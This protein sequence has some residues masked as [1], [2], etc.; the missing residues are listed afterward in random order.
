[1]RPTLN[2]RKKKYIHIHETPYNNTHYARHYTH[3]APQNPH[4]DATISQLTL[5][6]SPPRRPASQLIKQ[7]TAVPMSSTNDVT[8]SENVNNK[9]KQEKKVKGG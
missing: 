1:M 2:K 7:D 3:P 6:P 4:T 8:T 9:A 5:P